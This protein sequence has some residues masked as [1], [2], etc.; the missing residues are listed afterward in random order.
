MGTSGLASQSGGLGFVPTSWYGQG[1]SSDLPA[2][3]NA[4]LS[5]TV[6]LLLESRI[7]ARLA[8]VTQDGTPRVVPIWFIWSDDRLVITTFK[9]AKKLRDLVEGVVVAVTIDT[10]EFPYRS[11]KLRGPVT[12][13]P[14]EGIA[15]EYRK[16]AKRYV[17][18]QMADKW[19]AFLDNPDQ[20]V[21]SIAPTWAV[22]SD[23][24]T[25][26][27]FFNSDPESR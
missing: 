18:D 16:A 13:R 17:G 23:M 19:L 27:P 24:A 22:V 10:D 7:P 21:L 26:S 15:D 12:V 1:M 9:R 25:D 8:W 5:P 20:V 11:L 14:T 4:P 2:I 3:L 6:G